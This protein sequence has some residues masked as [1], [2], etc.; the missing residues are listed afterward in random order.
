MILTPIELKNRPLLQG[1]S[2]LL[3]IQCIRIAEVV[4]LNPII[5]TRS[6]RQ[7]GILFVLVFGLPV[8]VRCSLLSIL[9]HITSKVNTFMLNRVTFFVFL[10]HIG[11]F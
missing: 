5:S 9:A 4:G 7:T 1:R 8:N 3:P 2:Y 11:V 10:S 6:I